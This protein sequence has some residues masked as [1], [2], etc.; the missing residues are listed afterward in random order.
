MLSIKSPIRTKYSRLRLSL[1]TWTSTRVKNL[2]KTWLSKSF[3]RLWTISIEWAQWSVLWTTWMFKSTSRDRFTGKTRDRQLGCRKWCTKCRDSCRFI[4]KIL[5]E[6][7]SRDKERPKCKQSN[8]GHRHRAGL[9]LQARIIRDQMQQVTMT[10]PS[11]YHEFQM[12]QLWEAMLLRIT[13]LSRN[14]QLASSNLSL[15]VPTKLFLRHSQGRLSQIKCYHQVSQTFKFQQAW[16]CLLH[17]QLIA[18]F[19]S[20]RVW[21]RTCKVNTR[22]FQ[23]HLPFKVELLLL[24]SHSTQ[25]QWRQMDL[26]LVSQMSKRCK[27]L[28][29]VTKLSLQL[30]TTW[31]GS[32]YLTSLS[33]RINSNSTR[34]KWCRT[35]FN[36]SLL[37]RL[38]H[39]QAKKELS[40]TSL[41]LNWVLHLA[42]TWPKWWKW[43]SKCRD[44]ADQAGCSCL[45]EWTWTRSCKWWEGD[46]CLLQ[47]WCHL[48]AWCHLLEWCHHL[49]WCLLQVWWEAT[50]RWWW[51]KVAVWCLH[52]LAKCKEA[53]QCKC[54]QVVKWTMEGSC[55][56]QA[57]LL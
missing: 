10:I 22:V 50:L 24:L 16:W 3:G 55:H 19:K 20:H 9:Q 14:S 21:H 56:Q 57:A 42:K 53:Y 7:G 15:Q 35:W 29:R 37:T 49:A 25:K 46:K 18:R 32:S 2:L 52:Q 40:R 17:L 39:L 54:L 45:L 51:T 36:C 27:V 30:R 6:P 47:E 26:V 13:A 8:R 44:L 31:W 34:S 28:V 38:D 4:S 33:T 1:S 48:Q 5:L 41:Q 23:Q 43:C 11:R 12:C